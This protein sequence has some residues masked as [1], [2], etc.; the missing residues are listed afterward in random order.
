MH[1]KIAAGDKVLDAMRRGAAVVTPDEL[2]FERARFA[3]VRAQLRVATLTRDL[4]ATWVTELQEEL[5]EYRSLTD[6]L[7]TELAE[8]RKQLGLDT[9]EVGDVAQN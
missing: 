6:A 5:A 8:C 1:R 9:R 3:E 2:A 4:L 7:A